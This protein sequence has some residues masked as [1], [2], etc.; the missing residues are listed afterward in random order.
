MIKKLKRKVIFLS[1]SS[2]LVL[3]TVI[4]TGMNLISYN[5]V[6]NEADQILSL[7]SQ[8][9]G[10]FPAFADD[11]FE[12]EMFGEDVFED[13]RF[14]DD[15]FGGNKGA[16]L[17]PGMS[18][19]LQYESRYFSVLLTA[20][21][22]VIQVETSRI[23]RINT[24]SA[25]AYAREV[26]SDGE[27][28]GLIHQFRYIV[29]YEGEAVRITFLDCESRL[30]SFYDFMYSSIIMA[31]VGY[32]I[33]FCIIAFFAGRII[34]P[35]SESYE[36]QKQFITDA[37]HEIKTPLTIINANVDV[38]EMELGTNECLEDMKQ[39]TKRLTALTNDLVLLARMEESGDALQMI[40]FPVSDVVSEVVSSFKVL[41]QTQ[42]QEFRC[43]IQPMLT[44]KGNT[45][46][47]EQLISILM[48]NAVKYCPEKGVIAINFEKRGRAL[49]LT[50]SNTTEAEMQQESLNHVFDRFYRTDASRNSE[51]GGHG[52]G[53]S[54]AKAIV[55]AHSGK[56]Y[57]S[58]GN[59]PSFV[60][61]VI[62]PV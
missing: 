34:R 45:K 28:R 37:G 19:E 55:T 12:G 3:L 6:V 49:H 10:R 7:L 25:I 62:L 40:D 11:E 38:L 44:M 51:T 29:T 15:K 4:V 53:L 48:D 1:M 36:K 61:T 47:M 13:E 43:S 5:S 21:S 59:A 41:A 42:N 54:V 33:V 30:D 9:K 27:D 2:L 8:N 14:E 50:V 60:I 17:P 20:N 39:Q 22:N 23:A 56:I 32:V 18:I 58:T 52:I 57:A 31:V 16:M 46:T 26:V 24:A 35:I